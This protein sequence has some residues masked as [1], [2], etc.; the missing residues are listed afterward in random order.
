MEKPLIKGILKEELEK[1]DKGYVKVPDKPGLGLSLDVEAVQRHLI[2]Q[3]TQHIYYIYG[4]N[5]DGRLRIDAR[6]LHGS[7]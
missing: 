3:P 6:L 1:F 4:C 5:M 7:P 2:T